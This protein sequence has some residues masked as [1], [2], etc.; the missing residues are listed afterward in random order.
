MKEKRA[1][2]MRELSQAEN[3][4][5]GFLDKEDRFDRANLFV[6]LEQALCGGCPLSDQARRLVVRAWQECR[7]ASRLTRCARRIA[8][9]ACL[10]MR[11]G[12]NRRKTRRREAYR[13]P[14]PKHIHANLELRCRTV[15]QPK[16][17]P[18]EGIPLS[19]LSWIPI[20]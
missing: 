10:G 19:S 1:Q 4:P 8:E 12:D 18:N 14:A 2:T 17:T 16:N 6:D 9:T 13:P 15:L 11:E 20:K 5:D 3:R 7:S